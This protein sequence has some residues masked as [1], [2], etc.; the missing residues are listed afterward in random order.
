MW[1]KSSSTDYPATLDLTS[2]KIYAYV[3]KNI[4]EIEVEDEEGNITI[5]YTY[6]EMKIP[7]EVYGIFE[8]TIIEDQR[9]SDIED[10]LTEIIGGEV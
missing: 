3:R 5:Q 2:S 7:K 8:Q 1:Y 9:I 10:V 4:E 6:D